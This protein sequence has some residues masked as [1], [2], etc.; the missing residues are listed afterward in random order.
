MF[1]FI[2]GMICIP[3]GLFFAWFSI[4]MMITYPIII[5]F[6]VIPPLLWAAIGIPINNRKVAKHNAGVRAYLAM[7]RQDEALRAERVAAE[8]QAEVDERVERHAR[9][10]RERIAEYAAWTAARQLLSTTPPAEPVRGP[11]RPTATQADSLDPI[12]EDAE[13]DEWPATFPSDDV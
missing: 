12:D 5:P 11:D 9:L 3:V 13:G 10:E 2:I 6:V 1:G 4:Q 8:E 7:Q